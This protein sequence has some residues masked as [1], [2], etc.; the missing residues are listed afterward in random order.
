MHLLIAM[1]ITGYGGHK[2]GYK[3]SIW[4]GVSAIGI[5]FLWE[6]SNKFFPKLTGSKLH[7]YADAVDF[8]AFALGAVMGG[9]G[10]NVFQTIR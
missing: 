2:G 1:T 9:I 10:W 6:M 5:G 7:P 4:V 3:G 8:W